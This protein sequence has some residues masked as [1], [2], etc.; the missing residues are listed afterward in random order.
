MKPSESLVVSWDSLPWR[1]TPHPGVVWKKLAYDPET[2]RSAVL[3]RFEPG[4]AY[5]AH[6]HPGGEEYL[7]LEGSLEDG[8]SSY[9][10]GTY[11]RHAAGSVHRPS[12]K[13][14]CLLFV[15]LPKPIEEIGPASGRD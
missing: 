4:A 8:G 10:A 9:G 13:E 5:G 2:G 15:S 3:L 12:S 7:V 1:D 14:G 11:V 6:R